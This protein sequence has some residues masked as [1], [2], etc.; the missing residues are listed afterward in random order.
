M[1]YYAKEQFL[2]RCN[3]LV[4][5]GEELYKIN[6]RLFN[7]DN[8]EVCA[9]DS[10]NFKNMIECKWIL[11]YNMKENWRLTLFPSFM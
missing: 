4:K 6:N 2:G 7:K 8:I 11:V 3:N 1:K 10:Y 5:K 9:D